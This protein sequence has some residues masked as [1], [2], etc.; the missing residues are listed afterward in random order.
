MSSVYQGEVLSMFTLKVQE[1]LFTEFSGLTKASYGL[2]C[3]VYSD[4]SSGYMFEYPL[5]LSHEEAYFIINKVE[6]SIMGL[7]LC[8][9]FKGVKQ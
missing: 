8:E 7:T 4:G 5:D 6:E 1:F 9:L 2:Y 3:Q